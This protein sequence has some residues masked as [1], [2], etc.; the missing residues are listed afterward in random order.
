MNKERLLNLYNKMSD[1]FTGVDTKHSR[2]VIID[3]TNTFMRVFANVPA[4][5]DDGQHVGGVVGFLKSIGFNIRQFQAT[6]C[7]VVFDGS[8]GSL[9]RKKLYKE[10]KANRTTKSKLNRFAE[11]EGLIDEGESM[12]LQFTRIFEYL[13]ILPVNVVV[14]DNIEADDT[15]AYISKILDTGVNKIKIVSSDRDFL[16]LINDNINIYSP[17]KK[18]LYDLDMLSDELGIH[19]KNYLLYRAL[20]GDNSDNIPGINGVGLKTILKLFPEFVTTELD[21]DVFIQL[22]SDKLSIPLKGEKTPPSVLTNISRSEAELR[23]NYQLMQLQDVDISENSKYTIR[24]KINS[25]NKL[26]FLKFK[27]LFLYD[28]IYSSIKNGDEW[29]R[30]TFGK[31]NIYAG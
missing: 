26:D 20:T 11:F 27:E 9:R 2:T 16:Q 6:C 18:K 24:S 17:I 1:D 13:D 12:K 21:L 22:V 3:G 14:V 31:L 23:R 7:I 29:V 28:K 25:S 10:Y 4:L 30:N 19:P 5:N 8:G 15:I